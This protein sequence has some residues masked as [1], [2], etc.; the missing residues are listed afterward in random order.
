MNKKTL[1]A[2]SGILCLGS[3]VLSGC[4]QSQSGSTLS[5][6]DKANWGHYGDPPP[7]DLDKKIAALKA[8]G[9]NAG[10]QGTTSGQ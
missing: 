10:A 5:A 6:E 2:L 4:S 3:V 1:F 9:G 8:K 7:A